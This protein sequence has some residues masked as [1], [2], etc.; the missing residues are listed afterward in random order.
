MNTKL[1][2]TTIAIIGL[3][4]LIAHG[5]F[6]QAGTNGQVNP[7][8]GRPT[9]AFRCV[10]DG[11][12]RILVLALSPQLWAAYTTQTGNLWKVWRDGVKLD[13]TIYTTKHGPQPTTKGDMGLLYEGPQQVWKVTYKGV[14]Q[15]L[16]VQYR[17]HSLKG[18]SVTLLTELKVK[19]G[20]VITVT[21]QPE[22]LEIP[23]VTSKTESLPATK[24]LL[25][26]FTVN[27]TDTAYKVSQYIV[28]GAQLTEAD[29][30]VNGGKFIPTTQRRNFFEA[31][32]TQF[33]YGGW[34]HIG[35]NTTISHKFPTFNQQASH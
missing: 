33:F 11:Q 23:A 10:L 5:L 35:P 16:Q 13:G 18:N 1:T 6:A 7:Q 17:G 2:R 9:W 19:D 8:R 24:G 26:R 14:V 22:V 28:T 27:T 21:E 3:L 31:G 34:L 20:P 4:Q 12:P 32:P 15:D 30:V 25:R 29:F